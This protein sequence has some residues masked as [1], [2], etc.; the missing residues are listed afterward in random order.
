MIHFGREVTGNLETVLRRE[1][2]VTNGI[3]GYAMGAVGGARTRRYHSLLTASLQPPTRR[4]VMVGSLDTWVEINGR[5]SPLVTH[6]WAAGVVLP[7]GYR[8][9][10]S[11]TLDGLIPTF[12]WSLGDVQLEQ[13]I[14]M[15]HGQNTTYVTYTYTRGSSNIRLLLKPLCTY[16]DH[17]K[18][19]KGGFRVDV[20][21]VTS[22]WPEGRALAV[23]V[24]PERAHGPAQP[25]RIFANQG[26]FTPGPEWWWS[27][28][29]A[30]EEEGGLDDQEDLFAAGTLVADVRPGDTLAMA[31]TAAATDPAPWQDAYDAERQRQARLIAR[32]D[33]A[34]APGWV[35]QLVL[36]ADQFI[37]TRDIEGETGT[38]IL[39][40]YPWFS[41]WGRDAMIA[42]PGLT[43]VTGRY[44]D[45]ARILRTFARYVDH[46]ML[47]NRFPDAGD[48]PEYNTVDAA[49]WYFQA[50]Y[51]YYQACGESHPL[52]RELYPAML[53]IL[54]WYQKGTRFSIHQDQEDGLLYAGEAGAQ[55]TWM[56]VKIDDWVVTPRVG[57]PVEINALW[58]NALRITAEIGAA[59]DHNDDAERFTREADR[60]YASFNDRFWYSGGYLYDV[61]DAP[62]G[63]DP[64]LRPNQ[65]FAVSLPFPLLES[66]HARAVVSICARELVTSYGLRSLPPDENDYVGHYGGDPVQRDASYHQGTVWSWLLGPF[67]SA[68]Y[69]AFGD[70]RAAFSYLEPL[71]DHLA[72]HGLG[73]ISE[74]FDADPAHAPHGC[75][76]QAWS[77]GEVLRAWHALRPVLQ[78]ES[79]GNINGCG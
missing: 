17:H 28:H 5:R 34:D 26:S 67:V 72:D 29:L 4:T 21:A 74:I 69:R 25:F 65:I 76:A 14:W 61:I 3:G 45:G 59:L 12:V 79:P 8:H 41:D 20:N 9:L 36:A 38:S 33:A 22:P 73:S 43:L 31:F 18:V 6:E 56:D 47:P 1:W 16:R 54:S 51:A 7:D 49:L 60:V 19:T 42:L 52:I 66:E 2:L 10:E 58:Y 44:E 63:D 30:R 32:A 11:F 71:A 40:G 57:K 53:D 77:V 27:F 23:Q 15:A 35:R 39:A 70:A 78:P 37:V 55:L 48:A 68:H 24:Y 64:T 46:G 62:E 13:R 50:I 75:I